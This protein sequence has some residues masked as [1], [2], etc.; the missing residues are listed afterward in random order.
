MGGGIGTYK[1]LELALELLEPI[2]QLVVF[3]VRD[4]G[5]ALIVLVL[6]FI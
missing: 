5:S 4:A 3:G 6:I 2:E 1:V